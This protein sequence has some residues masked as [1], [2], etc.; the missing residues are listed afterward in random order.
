MDNEGVAGDD[1]GGA[2]IA[3]GFDR[4]V[5]TGGSGVVGGTAD[6]DEVAVKGA[7][8]FFLQRNISGKRGTKEDYIRPDWLPRWQRAS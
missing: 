4:E 5:N 6:L 2:A 1:G 7:G 3:D 8:P